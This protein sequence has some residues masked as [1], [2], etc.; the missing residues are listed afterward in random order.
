[1]ADHSERGPLETG[2]PM[3]Y[4]QADT[5]YHWFLSGAKYGTIFCAALLAAMAFGFFIGGWFSGTVLFIILFAAGAF[6]L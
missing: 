5:T 3:D 4:E 6:I 1:M 2:A